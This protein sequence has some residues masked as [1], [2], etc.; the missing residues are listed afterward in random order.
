[1]K[2]H[3]T[4]QPAQQ[5]ASAPAAQ[6]PN[7]FQHGKIG[8]AAVAAAAQQIKPKAVKRPEHPLPACLRDHD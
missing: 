6:I 5:Q 4:S 3:T 7:A 2:Q 1:M 8:L